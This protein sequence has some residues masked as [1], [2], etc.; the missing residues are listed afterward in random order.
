MKRRLHA[1][2]LGVLALILG[3]GALVLTTSG[4]AGA[5]DSSGTVTLTPSSGS[6]SDNPPLTGLTLSNGCPTGFQDAIT[7]NVSLPDLGDS[8]IVYNLTD[9][10]PYTASPLTVSIPA[11]PG[12]TTYINSIADAFS[13]YGA[14]VADG[15]YAVQVV[16]Q[17]TGGSSTADSTFTTLIDITGNDWAVKQ[18]AP[19]TSTS[20]TVAADPAAYSIVSHS[21]TLSATVTP[22]GA[23]GTL[24]FTTDAG[25]PLGTVPVTGGTA[26]LPIPVPPSGRGIYKYQAVFTPTDPTAFAAS[27][28]SML[29]YPVLDEP[30]VSVFDDTGNNLADTPTL[31][32]GQKTKVNGLGFMPSAD[33]ASTTG[34][35]TVTVT[36]DGAAGD[37][38]KA[39]PNGAGSVANYDFT[40]PSSLSS[41]DHTLKLKGDTTGVELTFPFKVGTDSSGD[42]SGS[43]A[44]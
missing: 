44:G 19:P 14:T 5:D 2:L 36:L 32:T 25:N 7:I 21:F 41:G 8:S 15:T 13:N 40:V 29:A 24:Q 23:A 33:P 27:T 26:S 35:E 20:V 4:T 3:S 37:L 42:T 1:A 10:A 38:A 11:S 39:T 30:V 9:G 34:G 18:A 17:A 12:P 28:S 6:L 16:C 43:T 22:S 31:T